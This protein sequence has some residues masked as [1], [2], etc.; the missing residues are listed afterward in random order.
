[1]NMNKNRLIELLAISFEKLTNNEKNEITE[2]YKLIY[3]A[4]S[5]SSCKNKSQKYYNQLQL[6]GIEKYPNV[7]IDGAFKLRENIGVISIEFINGLVLSTANVTDE[8]CIE[9]LKQNPNRI[10][11]FA[12]YPDN[13]KDLI[14][15]ENV[16]DDEV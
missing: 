8:L 3:G 5:C 1:M 7:P 4:S 11:M 13:W 2:Y 14:N 6:D 16:S 15:N 12:S 9:F 10:S